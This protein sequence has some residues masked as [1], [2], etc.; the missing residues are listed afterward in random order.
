MAKYLEFEVSLV[1]TKPRAW[2]RFVLRRQHSTFLDLHEAIQHAC[3]SEAKRP[4]RVIAAAP[5]AGDGFD[6]G[7]DPM[8]GEPEPE[9]HVV[10]LHQFFEE[11][12]DA[13]LY[14]Y[15]FGDDWQHK[16]VLKKAFES[17]ESFYRRLTGGA[18]AF[19]MEDCG[20][21]W[22]YYSCIAAVKPDFFKP[23]ELAQ[24]DP[25]TLEERREWVPDDWDPTAFD[26]KA[27]SQRF[28]VNKVEYTWQLVRPPNT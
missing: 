3:G 27:E 20:G 11:P 25:E 15:D 23:E 28:D 24:F 22:G 21:L 4:F 7:V 18:L 1:G 10:P 12:K 14:W 6:W 19:P 16:V 17:K 9:A 13:A 2:R 5:G 26:L 8:T